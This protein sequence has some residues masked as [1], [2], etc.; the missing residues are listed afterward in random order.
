MKCCVQP[1]IIKLGAERKGT[2]LICI[3]PRV[4]HHAVA[5]QGRSVD[6]SLTVLC[7]LIRQLA[8]QP[9]Q[10]LCSI[11]AVLVSNLPASSFMYFDE[12]V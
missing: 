4:R 11:C 3:P 5:K 7:A 12:Y 2:T 1:G 9:V 8:D 6:D 10:Y